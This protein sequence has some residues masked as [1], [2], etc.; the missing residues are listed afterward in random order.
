MLY[1]YCVI[2]VGKQKAWKII[3]AFSLSSLMA[4]YSFP[5]EFE[6]YFEFIAWLRYPLIAILLVAEVYIMYSVI[7]GLWSA[8]KASGDPRITAFNLNK[9]SELSQTELDAHDK[10]LKGKLTESF[11]EN[12]QDSKL[13]IGVTLATEPASWYY[14]IPYF[15]RKH[16]KSITQ[17]KSAMAK[18]WNVFLMLTG[19]VLASTLSYYFL[20]EFSLILA[21][22]VSGFI[23]YGIVFA[24][25]NYRTAKHYSVYLKGEQ[26]IINHG[27]WSFFC[28]DL[29]NIS[30]VTI[31]QAITDTEEKVMGNKSSEPIKISFKESQV[32]F[33]SF[34]VVQD[35]FDCV[36]LH[37]DDPKTL[38]DTL[39][40]H[41]KP[42]SQ[43]DKSFNV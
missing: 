6:H 11:K 42:H 24:I 18:N 39:S 30:D 21:Y 23:A 15:S 34:S 32:Y 2:T 37:V 3:I 26:L 36:H 5:Q 20:Y 13:R 19:S 10:N 14:A 22:F 35:K 16:P 1:W 7:K 25:A 4:R 9:S 29:N 17:V 40:K 43:D 33:G 38:L 31:G 8:R 12:R 41:L 27:L 28:V